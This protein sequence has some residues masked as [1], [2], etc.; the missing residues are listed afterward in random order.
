[1]I[2]ENYV[3]LEFEK[4]MKALP[5]IKDKNERLAKMEELMSG[6]FIYTMGYTVGMRLFNEYKE[7]INEQF[8]Q[9]S[10]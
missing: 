1:M 8:R 7:D 9:S 10:I 5:K 6:V 3:I 2:P 4:S